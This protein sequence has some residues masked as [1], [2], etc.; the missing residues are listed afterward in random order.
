MKN[1]TTSRSSHDTDSA[2]KGALQQFSS[3]S[4]LSAGNQRRPRM[5]TTTATVKSQSKFSTFLPTRGQ[6][7][8]TQKEGK[9][10]HYF[11]GGLLDTDYGRLAERYIFFWYTSECFAWLLIH[12][13]VTHSLTVALCWVRKFSAFPRRNSL[14]QRRMRCC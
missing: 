9:N 1:K 11:L 4:T 14:P 6:T 10:G 2:R 7:H 8:K 12:T 5:T 13:A 3:S